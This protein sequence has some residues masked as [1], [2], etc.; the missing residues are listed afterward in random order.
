MSFALQTRFWHRK[1]NNERNKRLKANVYWIRISYS[2]NLQC[3]MLQTAHGTGRA[4]FDHSFSF[5]YLYFRTLVIVPL[6][7]FYLLGGWLLF[8]GIGGVEAVNLSLLPL[9]VTCVGL[10]SFM[11]SQ[12]VTFYNMCYT[13]PSRLHSAW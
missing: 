2:G 5:P 7:D 11:A 3:S 9:V 8:I 10:A 13:R 4:S 1:R 12:V 6:I